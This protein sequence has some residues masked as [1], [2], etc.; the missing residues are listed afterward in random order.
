MELVRKA[1]TT[2]VAVILAMTMV[3]AMIAT[4]RMVMKARVSPVMK[5]KTILNS[6]IA[7][8]P[9]RVVRPVSAIS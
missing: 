9:K 4:C 3:T 8:L 5:S 1:G 2:T 6:E 7:D